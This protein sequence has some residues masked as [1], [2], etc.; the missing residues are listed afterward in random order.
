MIE[1]KEFW[2][3]VKKG[4][5]IDLTISILQMTDLEASCREKAYEFLIAIA[6]ADSLRSELSPHFDLWLK[7][8]HIANDPVLSATG[9]M[10]LAHL[11]LDDSDNKKLFGQLENLNLTPS[12]D[13]KVQMGQSMLLGNLPHCDEEAIKLAQNPA[14]FSLLSGYLK[15]E[16]TD[17]RVLHLVV[18]GLRNLSLPAVNKP[19]FKGFGLVEHAV[20]V[21]KASKNAPIKFECVRT[22]KSLLLSGNEFEEEF[23]NSGGVEFLVEVDESCVDDQAVRVA[24][25]AGRIWARLF[26]NSEKISLLTKE[27]HFVSPL[28]KLLE[29]Q[30]AILQCE[31]AKALEVLYSSG[32]YNSLS[33]K[34]MGLVRKLSAL[35]LDSDKVNSRTHCAKALNAISKSAG[36]DQIKGDSGDGAVNVEDLIGALGTLVFEEE[37][38]DQVEELRKKLATSP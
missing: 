28:L 23:Y 3:E 33:E 1:V 14:I 13:L 21:G 35:L 18:A 2:Q 36:V 37:S 8:S 22:V 32:K 31:G 19:L 15:N 20:R 7:M 6:K 16:S 4:S 9:A 10:M 11:S 24:L 34:T 12:S 38:K 27:D 30:F 29:S 26:E 5:G 17:E 25:E